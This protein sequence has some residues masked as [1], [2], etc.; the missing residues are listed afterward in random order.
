MGEKSSEIKAPSPLLLIMEGRSIFELGAYVASAP[1]FKHLPKGDGH[2]VLVLPGLAASDLS[3]GPLRKFLKKRGYEPY[4]W[5]QGR[6]LGLREQTF[7]KMLARVDEIFETHNRKLSII[8]WSLGGIFAR[9]LAKLRPEKV[10]LVISLGSP[11]SGNIKASHATRFYEYVAGHSVEDHPLDTTLSIAPPVPTTS[12]Y[13]KTDGIVAWQNCHQQKPSNSTQAA[14]IENIIVEGS[15]TGLGV[16][17][18]VLFVIADRLAQDEGDWAPFVSK[19]A[20]KLFIRT[21]SF[22]S[23][24]AA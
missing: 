3:T 19:G 10:R 21:P 20:R 23:V 14:T 15:H 13:T 17:P 7:E 12:I 6:N 16:N 4:A 11:H 2:P 24:G 5:E 22:D 9:E 1:L 18:S 8:G